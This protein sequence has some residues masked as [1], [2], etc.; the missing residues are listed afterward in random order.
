MKK[1]REKQKAEVKSALIRAGEDL[2]ENKG[3]GETTIEDITIAAGVARGTFYNY[4]QTKEDLALELIYQIDEINIEHAYEILDST[5]GI[6]NQI[7]VILASTAEWTQQ[8][9][10]LVWV[11]MMEKV[12]RGASPQGY[13]ASLFRRMI[14]EVFARGQKAGVVT[15]ER[16][17]ESLANDIDGLYMI[18]MARWYHGGRQTELLSVLLPAVNT[19]LFGALIKP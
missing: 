9:P 17:P 15:K 3:Y 16:S 11:A 2:F 7:R 18:H 14:T 19:Y 4:F 1:L 12:R 5:P 13:K 10:E 8:R 6:E